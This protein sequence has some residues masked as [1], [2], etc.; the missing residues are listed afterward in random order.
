MSSQDSFR[1]DVLS[2]I[3]HNLVD[4]SEQFEGIPLTGDLQA[5]ILRWAYPCAVRTLAWLFAAVQLY[6]LNDVLRAETDEKRFAD[7]LA[8]SIRTA[9]QVDLADQ[10]HVHILLAALR[11][12][13]KVIA[14]TAGSSHKEGCKKRALPAS[15]VFSEWV[16]KHASAPSA[17]RF[18]PPCPQGALAGSNCNMCNSPQRFLGGFPLVYILRVHSAIFYPPTKF[19]TVS[20]EFI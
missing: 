6:T 16:E 5:V 1:A 15:L 3:T 17:K 13:T 10:I 2:G 12:R 20:P 7:H 11:V 8:S 4:A 19:G 9:C 14:L 18:P